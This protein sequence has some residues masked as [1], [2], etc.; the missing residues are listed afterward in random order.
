MS[1]GLTI[2]LGI[3]GLIAI[4]LIWMTIKWFVRKR[5]GETLLATKH[6]KEQHREGNDFLKTAVHFN[7]VATS[8]DVH[9]AILSAIQNVKGVDEL[10]NIKYTAAGFEIEYNLSPKKSVSA[11]LFTDTGEGF[12]AVI[13]INPSKNGTTGLFTITEVMKDSGNIFIRTEAFKIAM[14]SRNAVIE[15]FQSIDPNVQVKMAVQDINVK[16]AFLR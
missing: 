12:R 15:A 1:E 9:Q 3:V 16:E 4:G 10:Y 8:Q 14:K 6:E 5:F 11:F 13:T 2:F 7:T